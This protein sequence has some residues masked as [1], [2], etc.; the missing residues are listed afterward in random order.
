MSDWIRIYW[1]YHVHEF[2]LHLYY[3]SQWPKTTLKG[4][5]RL[6][7]NVQGKSKLALHASPKET[8]WG[9]MT[10]YVINY[11]RFHYSCHFP[12]CQN[13]HL[14]WSSHHVTIP[15]HLTNYSL[16]T[17][18]LSS[19]TCEWPIKLLIQLTSNTKYTLAK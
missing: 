11:F 8:Q 9:V 7:C 12:P 4:L 17:L 18:Y 10:S 14:L 16:S 5:G 15:V 6:W 13:G 19:I 3:R 1:C 2:W